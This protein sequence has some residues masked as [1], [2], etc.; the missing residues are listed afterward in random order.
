MRSRIL[1]MLFACIFISVPC[2]AAG[3][4]PAAPPPE[5]AADAEKKTDEKPEWKPPTE[6]DIEKLKYAEQKR[7]ENLLKRKRRQLEDTGMP[8]ERIRRQ[9]A[10]AEKKYKKDMKLR[11]KLAKLPPDERREAIIDQRLSDARV[12]LEKQGHSGEDL[13]KELARIRD[14]INMD[15]DEQEKFRAMSEEEQKEYTLRQREREIRARLTAG[16][17][18]GEEFDRALAAA[19]EKAKA[20]IEKSFAAKKVKKGEGKKAGKKPRLTKKDRAELGKLQ[21]RWR[22]QGLSD[23]DIEKRSAYWKRQRLLEKSNK[24]LA[25]LNEL[26]RELATV[27][28]QLANANKKVTELSRAVKKQSRELAK[29]RRLLEEIKDAVLGPEEEG[30]TGPKVP[31]PLPE[32][33][34]EPEPAQP[35]PKK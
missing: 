34:D 26:R 13:E 19:L 20:E 29:M 22:E 31:V 25:A 2:L 27:R 1:L 3:E 12:S 5:Q 4:E 15:L 8:E 28:K 33:P 21:A 14:E 16:G 30:D 9:L 32:P 7:L 24:S 23:G 18:S 35:Q 17:L 10:G 6:K 11:L